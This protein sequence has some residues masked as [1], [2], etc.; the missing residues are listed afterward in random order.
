MNRED[1][2]ISRLEAEANLT[3]TLRRKLTPIMKTIEP[4]LPEGTHFLLAVDLGLA[5]RGLDVVTMAT[6]RT[7]FI[8]PMRERAAKVEREAGE[9]G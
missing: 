2:E 7:R 1:D 9:G 5:A 3:A 8:V 6:D 4:L